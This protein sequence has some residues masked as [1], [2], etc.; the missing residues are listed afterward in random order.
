MDVATTNTEKGFRGSDYTSPR[1]ALVRSFLLSRNRWKS[2][3]QER[4][5]EIKRL[6]NHVASL[7][8]SRDE[9]KRRAQAWEQECAQAQAQVQERESQLAAVAAEKKRGA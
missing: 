2:K 1:H 5:V 3:A 7:Q 9:W 4:K 8:R 6:Q